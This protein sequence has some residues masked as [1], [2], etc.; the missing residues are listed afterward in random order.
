MGLL[1]VVVAMVVV[2]VLNSHHLVGISVTYLEDSVDISRGEIAS[3]ATRNTRRTVLGTLSVFDEQVD[4]AGCT[5]PSLLQSGL[6]R[7]SFRP[8]NVL[9]RG[10]EA[11]RG[12]AFTSLSPSPSPFPLS[13]E[14]ARRPAWRVTAPS[15]HSVPATG[16]GGW[17]CRDGV[18]RSDDDH[19]SADRASSPMACFRRPYCDTICRSS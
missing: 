14:P 12:P 5:S 15:V 2:N 13:R 3:Q 19:T 6:V 11:Q 1:S 7:P 10:F 4:S 17:G 8:W 9:W 16:A 18:G